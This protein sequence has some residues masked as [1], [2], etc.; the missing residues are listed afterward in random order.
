[1]IR[2]H[3][4]VKDELNVKELKT[5]IEY[6]NAIGYES[7]LFVFGPNV[8]DNL[9]LVSHVLENNQKINLM[10]AIRPNSLTA[11]YASNVISAYEQ[12]APGRLILNIVAGTYEKHEAL[13]NSNLN[14]EERKEYAGN[15]VKQLREYSN[16]KNFPKIV[17]SGCS[18]KTIENTEKYGDTVLAHLSDYVNYPET[19]VNLNKE[20]MARAWISIGDTKE[21]AKEKLFEFTQ[22]EKVIANTLCGTYESIILQIDHLESLGVTDLLVSEFKGTTKDQVHNLFHK[23]L[24]KSLAVR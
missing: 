4:I 2:F 18:K 23:Y 20:K 5:F 11:M 8:S 1:M 9:T 13:F 17:F 16:T 21:S 19:F 3:W 6:L 24:N 12:I 15:F 22:D 7:A 10:F 14:S